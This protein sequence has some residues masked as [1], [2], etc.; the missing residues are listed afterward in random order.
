MFIFKMEEILL[1]NCPHCNDFISID[2][3]DLNCCIFRHGFYIKTKTQ[4]NP[5]EKKEI[6]ED[7]FNKK[8]II[9]CGKPFKI[10]NNK[11]EICDW[12]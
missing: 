11:I 6:C 4:I 8:L 12:I 3:K 9:G 1:F 7:L 10:K 5:H 2:K